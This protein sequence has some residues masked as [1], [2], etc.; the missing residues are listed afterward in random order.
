MLA[1]FL[2]LLA[3]APLVAE[4]QPCRARNGALHAVYPDTARRMKI[5]GIVRLSLRIAADG[6]VRE[7]K[8]LGG[9]PILVTAAQ[10]SVRRVRFE[11]ADSCVVVFEFKN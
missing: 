7:V 8:V 4:E 10:D 5:E 9:N 6:Q 2:L 11:N 3:A 1:V